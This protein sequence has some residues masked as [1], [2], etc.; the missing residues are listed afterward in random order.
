MVASAVRH[1]GLPQPPSVA[2][3]PWACHVPSL[4]LHDLFWNAG[5]NSSATLTALIES[6]GASFLLCQMGRTKVA[7]DPNLQWFAGLQ[8]PGLE[9]TVRVPTA[10]C[11]S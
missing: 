4:C 9:R 2:E 3:R 8:A 11:P 5:N 1:L 6:L 10:C 7:P